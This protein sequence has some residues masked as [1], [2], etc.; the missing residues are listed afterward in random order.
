MVNLRQL[1]ATSR[2]LIGVRAA[3]APLRMVEQDY[4]PRFGTLARRL[5]GKTGDKRTRSDTAS[6]FA[7]VEPPRPDMEEAPSVT[8][9]IAPEVE[10]AR[11]TLADPTPLAPPVARSPA[12]RSVKMEKGRSAF[13]FFSRRQSRPVR[14]EPCQIEMALGRVKVM[15]N[16]LRDA[17]LELVEP[18]HRGA[19]E[20]IG[21]GWKRLAA[22]LI[23][24]G[25]TPSVRIEGRNPSARA[26]S[27]PVESGRKET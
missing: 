14:Q 5:D 9:P 26:A 6:P 4:L 27:E 18:R 12:P 2:S 23:P 19:A 16:D 21:A 13:G 1:L 10:P 11:Q 15:R 22:A 20:Q 7:V 25:G 8:A 24:A 3:P 17:D